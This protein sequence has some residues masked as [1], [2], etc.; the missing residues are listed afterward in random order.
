MKI[1]EIKNYLKQSYPYFYSIKNVIT[2]SALIFLMTLF[3]NYFFEPFEVNEKQLKM[4]FF[5][6]SFMHALVSFFIVFSGAFL[7]L[8]KKKLVDQWTIKKETLFILSTLLAIGLG[9]FLIRDIIYTNPDNWSWRYFYEEIR[10][11]F[12]VGMLFL[13]II[14]PII[15]NRY[16]RKHQNTVKHIIPIKEQIHTSKNDEI[17]IKTQLKSDTFSLNPYVLLFAL[18]EGNY[19]E[20]YFLEENKLLKK[21]LRISLKN[22]EIQLATHYFIIRTHRS[23]LVNLTQIKHIDGNAQGLKLS[24]K[25]G[26]EK[27]LVSRKMIPSFKKKMERIHN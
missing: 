9:Q 19:T 2:I 7:L 21:L 5:L 20:I 14:V 27:A 25:I 4:N 1:I 23:F 15:H 10:N 6:I 16:L 18:S 26:E 11:T 8:F 12:L 24:F 17:L 22:L 3:F 13:V